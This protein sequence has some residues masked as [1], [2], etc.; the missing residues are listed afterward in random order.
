MPRQRFAV[1]HSFARLSFVGGLALAFT[2]ALVGLS[3][4]QQTPSAQQAPRPPGTVPFAIPAAEFRLVTVAEGLSHP[5]NLAFLPDGNMLITERTGNLRVIRNG[6]L[7][8]QPVSGVPQVHSEQRAGLM[9]LALHPKFAENKLIYLAYSKSGEQGITIALARGRFDGKALTDV[10]DIFVAD[11]WGKGTPSVGASAIAF[12]ADGMLYMTV[13]G[14]INSANTGKRA[15]DPSDHCGKVL[16][17]RDDGSVPND[18][19]FVGRAGYRPEIYSLGHRNQLGLAVHPQTGLLWASENAPQGGD[20][21]NVIL[22]GRNYGWPLVSYGREYTGARVT[23]RPWM[24]GM[25]PPEVVWIPSIAPSGMTFYSG[26]RFP[27]WKGNLFV[28]SLQTGRILRTGHLER[29]VFNDK[30]LELR[31]E[32]LLLDLKQRI[33]D[34]R[35]GPDGLLYVLTEADNGALL[36]IEPKPS[37]DQVVDSAG[38]AR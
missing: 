17:L 7:D 29:V 9:G 16:R 4:A 33:R 36:R 5:W 11:A 21:V 26:D 24:E 22:P 18:N 12:G 34:V 31:R 15:Q 38:A 27:S 1:G 28:A 30:G 13:G 37:A 10:R 6:V 3:A 8:P 14:A 2:V 32:S 35:Q 19:P 25:E 23:E 20:E